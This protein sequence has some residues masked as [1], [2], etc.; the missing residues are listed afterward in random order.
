MERECRCCLIYLTAENQRI[1]PRDADS[2]LFALASRKS[3]Q[4][5]Q[6]HSRPNSI[7]SSPFSSA[8]SKSLLA[9][10]LVGAS[11]LNWSLLWWFATSQGRPS[12]PLLQEFLARE[13]YL[14]RATSNNNSSNCQQAWESAK[15]RLGMRTMSQKARKSLLLSVAE[16]KCAFWREQ[17]VVGGG[18]VEL[19]RASDQSSS[20]LNTV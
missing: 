18:D 4:A 11:E 8:K 3:R 10:Q 19:G 14:T 9:S 20:H 2:I 7:L 17:T 15:G 12:L 13:T 6:F 16:C 1:V 5:S